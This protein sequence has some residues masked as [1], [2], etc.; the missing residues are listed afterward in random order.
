MIDLFKNYKL[1]FI[2]NRMNKII[3]KWSSEQLYDARLQ[4]DASVAEHLLC[5]L[6]GVQKTDLTTVPLLLIDTA[7]CDLYELETPEEESKGNEG[8]T[9]VVVQHVEALISS[10]VKHRDI[11]IITPY[12]LQV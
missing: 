10:G 1:N 5:D 11:G 3:M 6:E 4:A 7:G 12:N 2:S 9:E 8:E